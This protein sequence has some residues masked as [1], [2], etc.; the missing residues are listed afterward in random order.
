L[1]VAVLAACAAVTVE[2]LR[3]TKPVVLLG[4]LHDHARQHALRLEALEAWLKTGARPALVMEQFDRSQQERLD[5]LRREGAG[6][7]PIVEQL[8][9]R[10]WHWPFYRPFVALAI[11]HDLPIVAANLSREAVREVMRDGLTARG[12]L[13]APEG[14]LAALARIIEA[15]HCGLVDA[16]LARRM[17]QAQ[18][19]RD[20]SMAQAVEAHA[21]RGA[22][23][24]AGNGHV[25][26]D[27][28]VPLWLSEATRA[29]SEA[30]G[31]VETGDRTMAYDRR[32]VTPPHP[33]PDPCAGMPAPRR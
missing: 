8:G 2:P 7:D 20:Q 18:V 15:N 12:Y 21:A 27:I 17:A 30:I 3:F 25:R 13:G 9:T 11:E 5:A 28:G 6:A 32:V 26:T 10:G 29:R 1:L 22:V 24:L 23:L 33:R 19:A 14:T 31:V 16:A 4:E